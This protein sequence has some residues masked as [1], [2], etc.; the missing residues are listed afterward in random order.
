MSEIS[1]LDL[2]DVMQNVTISEV[3]GNT[4]LQTPNVQELKNII[5]NLSQDVTRTNYMYDIDGDLSKV[6]IKKS[7]FVDIDYTVPGV[8]LYMSLRTN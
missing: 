3:G 5:K 8:K 1:T 6:D 4:W 2:K 7:S